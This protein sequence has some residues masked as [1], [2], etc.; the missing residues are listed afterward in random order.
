AIECQRAGICLREAGIEAEVI[1]PVS[2]SPL[3]METI[4]LSV[5]KTGRL[6]GVD[7]AWPCCG[8]AG[9]VI[10]RAQEQGRGFE[11]R[12]LG[13]APVSC[14]TTKPV[15]NLFYPDVQRIAKAAHELVLGKSSWQP[16]HVPSPEIVQFKG[17]F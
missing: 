5:A 16:T 2:L 11:F 15:E 1:D 3:D 4:C 8:A 10:V 9:E 6:V 13:F 7:S 17:P 12:R 14:P